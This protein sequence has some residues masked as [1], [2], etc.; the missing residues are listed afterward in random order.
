[1]AITVSGTTITFND[2]TTQTT[3]STS[4]TAGNGITV[5][6]GVVALGVPTSS[7]VGTYTAGSTGNTA[8][9]NI[10]ATVAGSTLGT[11][12]IPIAAGDARTPFSGD[13]N[14]GAYLLT[15]SLTGTWRACSIAKSNSTCC[16]NFLTGNLYIRIA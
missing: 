8:Q 15:L 5:T 2:A 9:E 7:S 3:A 16:G 13:I 1:M 12:T 14:A 6:S 11:I 4:A 10:G